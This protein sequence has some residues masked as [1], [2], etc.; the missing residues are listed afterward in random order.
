MQT[1]TDTALKDAGQEPDKKIVELQKDLSTLQ[2]TIANQQDTIEKNDSMF[3]TF[4]NEQTKE[5]ELAKHIPENA[6][7]PR[8]DILTLM[9]ANIKTDVDEAGNVIGIGDDGQP[10]KDSTLNVLPLKEVVGNFFNTNPHLLKAAE[11]GAGEGDSKGGEGKQD[12]DNFTKEMKE[13]G[14]EVNGAPF[15]KIMQERIKSGTLTV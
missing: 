7:L 12:L 8:I 11:G 3:T 6:L 13:Q 5:T 2:K 1:N 9:R 10:L 15:V 4:K 14:L